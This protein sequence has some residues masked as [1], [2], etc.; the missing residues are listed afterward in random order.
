MIPLGSESPD[1][2]SPCPSG[3]AETPPRRSRWFAD[4]RLAAGGAIWL[5][6]FIIAVPAILLLHVAEMMGDLAED[7]M[8]DA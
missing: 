4:F 3:K 5:V 1:I 2:G 6:A 8:G 7:V